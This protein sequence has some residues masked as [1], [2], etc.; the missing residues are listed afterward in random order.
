MCVGERERR[1]RRKGREGTKGKAER[2]ERGLY[3]RDE[4]KGERVI[5]MEGRERGLYIEWKVGREGYRD[6]R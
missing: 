6:G 4:R 1:E 2:M 3:C 5:E